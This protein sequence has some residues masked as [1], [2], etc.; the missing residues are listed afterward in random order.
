MLYLYDNKIYIKPV[1]YKLIEVKISKKSNEYNVE[2]TK[3]TIEMTAEI[4]DKMS[5]ITLENAY[6]MQNKTSKASEGLEK[7]AEKKTFIL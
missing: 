5:Q 6:K 7:E 2:P 1:E 4:R 3:K